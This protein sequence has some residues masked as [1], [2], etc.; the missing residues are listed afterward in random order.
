M[1]E[2]ENKEK[3]REKRVRRFKIGWLAVPAVALL[4]LTVWLLVN[5]AQQSGNA[6]IRVVLGIFVVLAVA[7]LLFK[8]IERPTH[9][10]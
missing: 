7:A 3:P 4:A 9:V 8:A 2:K 10:D 5:M 1:A 6:L